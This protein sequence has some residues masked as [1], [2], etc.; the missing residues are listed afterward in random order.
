MILLA[1][2]WFASAESC[3]GYQPRPVGASRCN[4][5]YRPPPFNHLGFF[6]ALRKITVQDLANFWRALNRHE[7]PP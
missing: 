3:N 2:N 4:N 7:P 5:D 6:E 1:R